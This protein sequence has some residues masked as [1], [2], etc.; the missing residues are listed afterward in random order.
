[1]N[2]ICGVEFKSGGKLYNF[3]VNGLDLKTND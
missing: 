2:N 3:S 1:M